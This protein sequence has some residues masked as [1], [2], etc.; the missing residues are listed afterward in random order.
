LDKETL[1]FVEVKYRRTRTAGSALEAVD[2]RKRLQI[3][4]MAQRYLVL[5]PLMRRRTMRFDCIG[6]D[7]HGCKYIK[8]AFDAHGRVT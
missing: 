4:D 5:H 7:D 2:R 1:A 6:I 8:N 3:V